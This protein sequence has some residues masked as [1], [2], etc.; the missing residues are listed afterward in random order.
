VLEYALKAENSDS[1]TEHP[2]V[3]RCI[4]KD[5]G[6]WMESNYIYGTTAGRIYL[7][8][9]G[10][11]VAMGYSGTQFEAF[12]LESID[13]NPVFVEVEPDTLEWRVEK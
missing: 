12:S 13:K 5:T 8:V 1:Y 6:E 4:R 2:I 10:T 11:K 9:K 3:Y 7:S